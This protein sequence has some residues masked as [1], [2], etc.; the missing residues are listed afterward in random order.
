MRLADHYGDASAAPEQACRGRLSR[1]RA[2]AV[3]W[4]ESAPEDAGGVA[5]DFVEQVADAVRRFERLVDVESEVAV[6][7]VQGPGLVGGGVAQARDR[8]AG[9]FRPEVRAPGS[10]PFD[11]REVTEGDLAFD[12]DVVAGVLGHPPGAADRITTGSI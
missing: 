12:A 2:T 10:A 9:P 3:G 5:V 4:L 7:P 11:D 6:A 1:G 8:E